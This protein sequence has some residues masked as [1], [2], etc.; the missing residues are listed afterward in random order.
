MCL[1]LRGNAPHNGTFM[2]PPLLSLTLCTI[3][4][5]GNEP[6][7]SLIMLFVLVIVLLYG[8]LFEL[9]MTIMFPLNLLLVLFKNIRNK[10]EICWTSWRDF[11]SRYGILLSDFEFKL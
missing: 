10:Y 7:C 3:S 11:T 8:P 9:C 5:A 4:R 1:R 2:I 6:V